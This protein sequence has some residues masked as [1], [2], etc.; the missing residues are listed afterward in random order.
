MKK[1]K[2][3]LSLLTALT[4]TASAFT[5]LVIPAS[6]EGENDTAPA[7]PTVTGAP[8]AGESLDVPAFS[9]GKTS[10]TDTSAAMEWVDY[11][12]KENVLH[13]IERNAY[14]PVTE[15]SEGTATFNTNVYLSPAGGRTFRIVLQNA[16]GEVYDQTAAFA[17]VAVNGED[18]KVY[19]GPALDN[20]GSGTELFTPSA[21]GWY[22]IDVTLDY[23]KKD[24]AEF[25]TVVAKDA[26]GTTLGTQKIGAIADKDTTLRAIRL[27]KTASEVYFADMKVTP[28]EII[29]EATPI[30]TKAP[31]TEAPTEAP[32]TPATD[33]PTGD[34]SK[35]NSID[36]NETFDK[37][38]ENGEGYTWDIATTANWNGGTGD[39]GAQG[40]LPNG[41]ASLTDNKDKTILTIAD[42]AGGPAKDLDI[43]FDAA[44]GRGFGQ[45]ACVWSMTFKSTDNSELFKINI[46]SG[47][48]AM[49][50]SL[51]AGGKEQATNYTYAEKVFTKM[52]AH[53]SF[54]E[55]GGTVT[56]GNVT[57]DFTSGSDLGSIEITTN[58]TSDQ[59]RPFVMDNLKIKTI[60]KEKV[61]FNVKSSENEESVAGAELTI[62]KDVYTVP[63]SGVVEAYYLPGDYEYSLKL[64]KHKAVSDTLKVVVAGGSQTIYTFENIDNDIVEGTLIEAEYAVNAERSLTSVKTKSVEIKNGKYS[65]VIDAGATPAPGTPDKRYM[66]WNTLSG[67]E[68][69]GTLKESTVELNNDKDIT[70]EYV[71]DPVPTKIEISGGDEYIYIPK[72]GATS[73]SKAFV[74]TVYDQS[75]LVMDN[76]EVE[77]TL[78]GQPDSISIADGVITL[79]S[80]Y[81][82]GDYNGVD[83]IVRATIKGKD[84]VDVIQDASIHINEQARAN[85]WD[86]VGP[87]VIKDGT[88]AT[89][90]IKNVLDQ[91]ENPYNEEC[92]FTLTADND[93]VTVDG[94]KVTPNMG[95][96]RTDTIKLTAT[97]NN[98][99]VPASVDREITV[100]G[101]DFYEPA[102]GELTASATNA[103]FETINDASV[104]VWPKSASA[105][106]KTVI[107]LPV[108]VA[109]T[110]GSAKMITFDNVWSGEK[111][112]GSQ[113]RSLKFKNSKGTVV[114]DIDFAGSTVVKGVSKVDGNFTGDELGRLEAAGTVSSAQ[115]IIKT[116]AEGL[117]S[118][119]LSYN[120]GEAKTY[121]L[122]PAA[123]PEG[124]TEAVI[125][126]LEDIA[127][128]ELVGGNGAPNDRML[129]LS[130]IIISDSDI[131]EVEI[132]GADKLAK[133]SGLTATKE[134]RGSVFSKVE[135]ETFTWSVADREGN[136]ISGV[137]ID[138]KGVLSVEDTVAADTVAVISYTSSAST[139]DKPRVA[140]HEVTIK[141]FA[142]IKSA[143]LT[144]PVAVNAGETV[145]YRVENV[146]DEYGDTV[147]MPVQFEITDGKDTIAT[148]D[149][150]T[151][152]VTTTGTLGNY[153]VKATIGNP[154]K[155][156]EKTLTAAAA[157]YSAVGEAS[158]NSVE[159]NVAELANYAADTKYLVTTATADG[160][161]VKQTDNVA[162]TNGKV[163]VDTTGA[164]KYEVSPIYTYDNVGNVA[165][166]KDIPV[167]DGRYEFKFVKANMTRGDIY[168]NGIMVGNNVDQDGK[169]TAQAA[170][171][172]E[173]V[174]DDVLVQGGKATVTMKDNTS[175][176]KSIEVRKN[177]SILGRKAHLYILGDSL[178]ADYHK[179]FDYSTGN[180][181][182][183]GD[184]QTGWGQTLRQ[185]IS[186]EVNVTNLAESGSIA[187]GL[188]TP[189]FT[190]ALASAEAGD[191]ILIE[192]GYNDTNP[193][194]NTS[195]SEMKSYLER[196]A[197]ECK[198]KG[199][200]F[201]MSGPNFGPTRGDTNSASAGYTSDVLTAANNKGVLGISLS[202]YGKA[203][204]DEKGWTSEYWG[205]NF[206]CYFSGAVQ[207]GLHLSYHG[208]MLHAS[209]IAQAI[210]DAQ[211][212]TENPELAASLAGLKLDKTAKTLT[213]SEGNTLTL[214][215]K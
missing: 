69:V 104:L 109:L 75:D 82:V 96:S 159:V 22:N 61:T 201:I 121:D 35:N 20:T 85:S 183:A 17:Q 141:D 33:N 171:S 114:F 26:E 185:F 156:V 99:V 60:D 105:E 203:Y 212:D 93:K 102:A 79:T 136:A 27:V 213:D 11:Q 119:V 197:D 57:A 108:P 40:T 45:A 47:G 52:N 155:T 3:L 73:V 210:S 98:A 122:N 126:P 200:V 191:Y 215:V 157:K 194:N 38:P 7:Q 192:C 147:T 150:A 132:S 190:S 5:G 101:Y 160:M 103:R 167:S 204:Y 44:T 158:G 6:A 94:M 9:L 62:G 77:W 174:V 14:T 90:T 46:S 199:V 181:P 58:G 211:Q 180:Q 91:Y 115:F 106:A 48:W 125:T 110:S 149:A 1:N 163:T 206:N 139:E 65:F 80:A 208:A 42:G 36:I 205:K 54:G 83:V 146:V 202:S 173:W 74:A 161:L 15:T 16:A 118:A 28:T 31:A 51:V 37:A 76:A 12:G 112:V 148:I 143:D 50:S 21:A 165:S 164:A 41:A 32:D 89:Y 128:I 87:A 166:G 152:V 64:A 24:T 49:S 138:Q 133:I 18:N 184:A 81:T 153:T 120:G 175:D 193:K 88:E 39:A 72:E 63:E 189:A 182:T 84:N 29:T 198:A 176:M 209:L 142:A 123:I 162:H 34:G 97:L 169:G 116:D 137:T 25:I 53:V 145:N 59:G 19:V 214:Q 172:P 135:G 178:V 188:Y 78:P 134:F 144:G 71:G 140:T 86:I 70:L 68:P 170:S 13:I 23:T 43:A 117:T 129:S 179:T 124:E 168:V 8:G 95:T 195:A 207:D 113:E 4:I 130:N 66:L 187:R 196:M 127:T 177:P 10:E 92:E 30:P 107:T 2:K 151:G 186:D 131:A 111:T 55:N 100:Y 56:L 67:M 154:G